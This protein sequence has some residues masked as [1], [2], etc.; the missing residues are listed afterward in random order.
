MSPFLVLGLT[1]DCSDE[2]VR[3]AYHRLLREYPPEKF[4]VEFQQIHEAAA[5]LRTERD[6]WKTHLLHQPE[7]I[8]SPLET[9]ETFARLPGRSQPPGFP[10]FKSL[11]RACSSAA[12]K[13][14]P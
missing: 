11:L 14:Q 10:A 1:P 5:A 12:R 9:L 2:D 13:N 8:R 7:G 6:R 3:S 4:P